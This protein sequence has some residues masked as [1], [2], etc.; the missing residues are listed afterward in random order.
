[1]QCGKDTEY[2]IVHLLAA[3]DLKEIQKDA[4]HG[5]MTAIIQYKTPYVVDGKGPFI[6]SFALGNDVSLR[7]VLVLPT[8]LATGADI[9]LVKGLL[10]CIELNRYFPLDLQPPGKGLPEGASLNHYSP[11][12]PTSVPSNM[13][14][15]TSLLHHTSAESIPQTESSPTPSDNILVTDHFFHNTV[16]RELSYIP[17]NTSTRFA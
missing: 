1:M 10:S 11:T 13:K 8:L 17:T 4:N 5:Q 15:T 7:S 9:N 16:T 3:L 6:L 12:I 2:D 14:F